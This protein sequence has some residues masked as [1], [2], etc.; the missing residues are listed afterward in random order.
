VECEF[1]KGGTRLGVEVFVPFLQ[2]LHLVRVRR[3]CEDKLWWISSKMGLF[4]V[5]ALFYSL[6]CNEGRS[7]PWKNV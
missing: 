2:V 6:A 3:G 7:F 4:K 5:K 1:H